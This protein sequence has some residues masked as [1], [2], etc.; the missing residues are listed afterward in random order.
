L[1]VVEERGNQF[2]A[3]LGLREQQLLVLVVGLVGELRRWERL[4]EHRRCPRRLVVGFRRLVRLLLVLGLM[5]ER[6]LEEQELEEQEL[7]EQ[8]LEEQE[9][10]EQELEEQELAEQE[11]DPEELVTVPEE[12]G[13]VAH[14]CLEV[15]AALDPGSDHLAVD[16]EVTA[17]LDPG[18]VH[19]VVGLGD[20]VGLVLGFGRLAVDLDLGAVHLAVVLRWTFER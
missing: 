14:W 1:L 16:L 2:D 9:L 8:E 5:L 17:G 20:L 12:I 15:V 11:L 6:E 4:L 10:E 13:L 18:A 19:L 7:E 3:W